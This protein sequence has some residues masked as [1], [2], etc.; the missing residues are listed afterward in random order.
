[1]EIFE[2]TLVYL[3]AFSNICEILFKGVENFFVLIESFIFSL[4]MILLL[5]LSFSLTKRLVT[6]FQNHLLSIISFIDR[7]P[8]NVFSVDLSIFE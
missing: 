2:S 7:F 6:V 3:Q 8:N 4:K 1:M 5:V